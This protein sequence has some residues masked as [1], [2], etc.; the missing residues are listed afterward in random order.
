MVNL[1]SVKCIP[2]G[3]GNKNTVGQRVGL[4]GLPVLLSGLDNR[5]VG[6]K[7]I[8]FVDRS[9]N[10]EQKLESIEESTSVS[11]LA[12][13]ISLADV[14]AVKLVQVLACNADVW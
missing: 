13:K 4:F 5:N 1:N 7:V 3:N 12:R 6:I 14:V 9:I 2:W 8:K 11:L 10:T